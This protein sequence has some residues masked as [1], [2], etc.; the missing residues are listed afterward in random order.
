MKIEC[1]VDAHANVGEG[2][3]WDDQ[4]QVLWWTDIEGR[5][6]HCFDPATGH[7]T[8]YP[9]AE[10]VGSFAFREQGGFL[11]AID[12]GFAFWSP[13]KPDQL[14]KIHDP[15][16]DRPTNRFN[17]GCCDRQGRFI[18]SSMNLDEPRQPKAGIY[19]FDPDHSCERLV[20]GI[21]IGNGIAFSPD[22]GTIYMADT[23]S[24]TVWKA[25]YDQANGAIHDREVFVTTNDLAGMPDGATVDA[26]GRYWL[27]GVF[28]WQLYV[29]NPD[30]TLAQTIDMPTK[31]P[32]RPMFGG[33]NLDE[34]YVTTIGGPG[35]I[36]PQDPSAGG[37]YRITGLNAKGLPEPRFRG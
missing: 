17:D 18:G 7:D 2:P 26:E 28:G 22:G 31:A 14:D 10:R 25:R 9:M 5:K 35:P 30:G 3:V 13:E 32:S 27:A 33:A 6:M 4:N 1:V 12:S 20:D 23:P 37:L 36:D 16:A 34:L 29:F 24:Q 15:E 11:V 8:V 21:Q 19:R